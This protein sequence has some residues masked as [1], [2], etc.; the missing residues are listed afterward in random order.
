[1]GKVVFS[2]SMILLEEE[3]LVSVAWVLK[4]AVKK[5]PR[6]S[7]CMVQKCCSVVYPNVILTTWE[8]IIEI[9]IS[10]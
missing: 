2:A 3:K 9:R 10:T 8:K 7:S 4:E 5:R 1:M 6:E